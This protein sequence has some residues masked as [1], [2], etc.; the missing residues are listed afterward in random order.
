MSVQLLNAD[1]LENPELQQLLNL[2]GQNGE[3][4]R[5]NGGAVRNSLLGEP[6]ADIDL[7]TTMLPE[8]V[9][10]KL[11]SENIKVVP[12]GIDHGTVTAVSGGKGY[13]ITTLRADIE[14]DGRHAV[15][16]F[17]RDWL[18]DARRRDF[19][20]NA[21]YADG[22]GRVYD[23]LQ[24]KNDI[25]SRIVRF[26]G[27]A[28]DRVKEDHLRILRFFRFFAWY[29]SGAPDREGLKACVRT[30]QSLDNLSVERI[31]NELR[32]L[33]A[34]PDP[35][36]ALLWMRQSGVLNVVL[37]E[38]EKWGVDALPRLI[39][40][41]KELDWGIDPLRRLMAIIPPQR[42][43]VD[44]LGERLKLSNTNR[45]RLI[46]WADSPLPNIDMNKKDLAKLLY[47]SS[48]DGIVDVM[49]LELARLRES[50]AHNN[51]DLI[52]ASKLNELLD[53]ANQWKKP[54][55]PVKGRDLVD[56]GVKPG[57]Q[58]GQILTTLENRWIDSDFSLAKKTLMDS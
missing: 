3:E 43:V 4:A 6:V 49:Q 15:V 56:A 55:F 42:K 50:G 36:R 11:E 18:E 17:G 29:G 58:L 23:P 54:K 52:S 35:A 20:I 5:I 51:D 48:R 9:I 13:E 19:T 53:F 26:I 14:T 32:K 47:R 10:E 46:V 27:N 7:S 57:K 34:A 45:E 12:T 28:E 41:E 2:L 31:W 30:R 37:P 24:A 8:Q 38:S 25:E 39:Q 40:A 1:W 33:L 21:L 44:A 22:A 16:R